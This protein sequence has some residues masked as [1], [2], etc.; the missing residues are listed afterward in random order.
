MCCTVVVVSEWRD[1][2]G[3]GDAKEEVEMGEEERTTVPAVQ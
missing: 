2:E 1:P 3:E